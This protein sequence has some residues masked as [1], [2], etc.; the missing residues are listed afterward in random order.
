MKFSRKSI[1]FILIGMAAF[2]LVYSLVRQFLGIRFSDAG[3]KY[4]F[5]IFIFA[6]LGIFVYNRKMANDEKKAR[7]AKEQAEKLAAGAEHTAEDA[8][9]TIVDAEAG[10]EKPD[11]GA[12]EE[13]Q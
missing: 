4:M 2:I 12:K 5:D 7:E 13:A 6:A 3:E 1:M 8:K 11:R 10:E 9:Y